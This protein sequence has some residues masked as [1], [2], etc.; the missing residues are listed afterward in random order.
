MIQIAYV[1]LRRGLLTSDEIADLMITSR[2]RNHA[3]GIT[4]MLL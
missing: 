1:S 3:R 2:E 4:G